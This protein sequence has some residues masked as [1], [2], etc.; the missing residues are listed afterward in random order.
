MK[1]WEKA[2]IMEL[3]EVRKLEEM[4]RAL[5]RQ[6]DVVSHKARRS[7]SIGVLALFS[8]G[9]FMVPTTPQLIS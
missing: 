4:L 9:H 6:P 8:S 3:S 7:G 2:G 5:E 1:S